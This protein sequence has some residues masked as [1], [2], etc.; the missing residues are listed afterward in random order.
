MIYDRETLEHFLMT[1]TQKDES[2]IKPKIKGVNLENFD[3]LLGGINKGSA[4]LTE[5]YELKIAIS[6]KL[7]AVGTLMG[8][9]TSYHKGSDEYWLK[10]L[11]MI[12]DSEDSDYPFFASIYCNN[13]LLN[14][15]QDLMGDNISSMEKIYEKMVYDFFQ[16]TDC[17]KKSFDI[18]CHREDLSIYSKTKKD[19]VSFYEWVDSKI[20]QPYINSIIELTN[21][22]TFKFEDGKMNVTYL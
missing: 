10:D 1:N 19:M 4:T 3:I 16:D 20:V 12:R 22:D 6:Q 5:L 17:D 7:S 11:K 2:V 8:E 9:L 14:H 21:I 13:I 15:Y 18:H